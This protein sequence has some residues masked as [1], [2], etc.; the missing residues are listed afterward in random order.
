[1]SAKKSWVPS[2]RNCVLKKVLKLHS[3]QQGTG[4]ALRFVRRLREDEKRMLKLGMDHPRRRSNVDLFSENWEKYLTSFVKLSPGLAA[5]EV[6]AG[7]G[8]GKTRLVYHRCH[9]GSRV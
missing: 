8:K 1:M 9:Q 2:S 6:D 5:I 3:S 7:L 4:A